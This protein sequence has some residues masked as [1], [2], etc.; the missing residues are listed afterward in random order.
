MTRKFFTICSIKI[1]I[2][3]PGTLPRWGVI[4]Y[5]K[6][7]MLCT[8]EKGGIFNLTMCDEVQAG[9]CI[10][11][12]GRWSSINIIVIDYLKRLQGVNNIAHEGPSLGVAVQAMVS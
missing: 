10:Q 11:N 4:Q 9:I 3:T 6:A 5:R 7:N 8:N 12:S 1:Q 2:H